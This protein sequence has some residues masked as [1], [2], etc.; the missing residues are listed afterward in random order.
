MTIQ[1]QYDVNLLR[2][3]HSVTLSL[4]SSDRTDQFGGS[5]SPGAIPTDLSTD[6]RM[7]TLK[8]KYEIPLTTSISYASN[9]NQGSGGTNRFKFSLLD[10][11]GE[12]LFWNGRLR[13]YAGVKN[14]AASGRVLG[15]GV[16]DYTKRS[17][18]FG[19]RYQIDRS[20]V[21]MAE[22][23]FIRFDDHGFDASRRPNPSFNDSIVRL[24]LEKTFAF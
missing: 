3:D 11:H 15:G 19:G 7:I 8:T 16:I 20:T 6:V 24:R 9:D 12:Y 10:L 17:V 22:F 13:T 2:L 1:V 21:A 23:D 4:T 5:R 18:N 14:L